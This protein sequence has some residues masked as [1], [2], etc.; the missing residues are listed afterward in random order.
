MHLYRF[1]PFELDPLSRLLRHGNEPVRLSTPQFKVLHRLVVHAGSV[2]SKETLI[3]EAWGRAA[4]TE[5]SLEKAISDLRK[6]LRGGGSEEIWIETVPHQGYRLHA[7]VQQVRRGGPDAPY[8]VQLAPYLNFVRGQ[9]AID[10]L[11]RDEIHRAQCALEEVLRDAP[12]HTLAKLEL[13]MACGLAFDASLADAEP[14]AAS[15]ERGLRYVREVHAQPPVSGEAWSVLSYLLYLNGDGE[16]AAAASHRAGQLEPR[17][18]RHALREAYVTWGASRLRA[19]DRLLTLFPGLAVGHWFRATVYIARSTFDLAFDELR[20]GCAAQD[21]QPKGAG[22]PAVGLHFLH[23]L[24]LAAHGRLDEA[25]A[26]LKRELSW[27]DSG[28]LYAR[29][30]AA[31]TGYALGALLRRQRKSHEAEAAFTSALTIAPHH[32]SATAALRGEV[33][34]SAGPMEAAVGQAIMLVHRQRH[35]DAARVYRE[36]V[37]SAPR[38]SAGSLLPVEPTLNPHAQRDVW[39]DVLTMLRLRAS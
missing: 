29:T 26:A 22:F 8:E 2:V 16:E 10:T 1:G 15:L 14:D 9:R 24:V 20:C 18:F 34:I 35:A 37:A 30:C 36:A 33:P 4:I 11:D 27:A 38:A 25:M 39:G 23:G 7:Q 3:D 5:N 13:A 28:Q 6:V 17:E 31:N 19:A 32:V 21:A 12:E